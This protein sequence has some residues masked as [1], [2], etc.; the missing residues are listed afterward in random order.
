MSK[1]KIVNR[2]FVLMVIVNV[3]PYLSNAQ[4]VAQNAI[5]DSVSLHLV[6]PVDCDTLIFDRVRYAG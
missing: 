6:Y 3:V 1:I 4:N 2:L 5:P